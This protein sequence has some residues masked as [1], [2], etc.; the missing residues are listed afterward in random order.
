MNRKGFTLIE[1][2]AVILLLGII[3][4]LVTTTILSNYDNVKKN[5]SEQEIKSISEA[6]KLV[7]IDLS[8]SS[9]DIYNCKAGS[10]TSGKCKMNAGKWESFSVTLEDLKNNKYLE[11]VSRHCSGNAIVNNDQLYSVDVSQIKCN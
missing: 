1:L 6:L 5:L 11:D 8:D 7:A 9:S 4:T 3:G 10:W 2:L